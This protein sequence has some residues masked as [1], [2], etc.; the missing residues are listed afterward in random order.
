MEPKIHKKSVKV[1]D[2][3]WGIAFFYAKSAQKIDFHR[4][5]A[6][7]DPLGSHFG[8]SRGHFG[9]LREQFWAKKRR[10]L[11]NI[12]PGGMREAIES[13]ALLAAPAAC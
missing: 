11:P 6:D 10:N 5:K 8:A 13:A 7:V 2:P 3:H 1:G 9:S 12:W 4:S